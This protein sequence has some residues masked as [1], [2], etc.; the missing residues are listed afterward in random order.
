MNIINLI[1]NYI[2]ER[3]NYSNDIA[4]TYFI[5]NFVSH[6]YIINLKNDLIRRNYINILMKKYN[7]NYELIIVDKI[8][9]FNIINNNNTFRTAGEMG[10]Y[11]SHMYCLN[12]AKINNYNNIIIFEDDIIFH[13]QFLKL[14]ENTILCNND[15][16]ILLLGASDYNFKNNNCKLINTYTNTYIPHINTS[17]LYGTYSIYYTF[18]GINDMFSYKLKY[19]SHFDDKLI[20]LAKNNNLKI[21]YPN[22]VSTNIC[23]SNLGHISKINSK[24]EKQYYNLCFNN[25]FIF[26]C[27]NFIYLDLLSN[28][29]INIDLTISFNENINNILITNEYAHIYKLRIVLDFF[30]S[31]DLSYILTNVKI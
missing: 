2:V 19:P 31:N 12:D 28:N 7:I 15:A 8:T 4:K 17:F 29:N 11:L 10:C 3:Y 18:T 22:L 6:I 9:N 16:N 14:F 25:T 24:N 23:A 27:Y 26:N 1:N 13:K 5:N 21:C 20:Y 30:N